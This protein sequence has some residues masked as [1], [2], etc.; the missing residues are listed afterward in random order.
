MQRVD[1]GVARVAMGEVREMGIDDV[2]GETVDG[3]IK[4]HMRQA[5]AARGGSDRHLAGLTERQSRNPN[6]CASRRH[7]SHARTP[8]E[9]DAWNRDAAAAQIP[10]RKDSEVSHPS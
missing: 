7:S 9:L 3:A 8:S 10:S 4:V 2:T 5:L 1:I 6:R